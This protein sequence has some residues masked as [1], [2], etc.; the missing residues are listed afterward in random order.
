MH[1]Y[2]QLDPT[3]VQGSLEVCFMILVHHTSRL[4]VPRGEIMTS[5]TS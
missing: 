4:I 3:V 2:S 5:R 1:E